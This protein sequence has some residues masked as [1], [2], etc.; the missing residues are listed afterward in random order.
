MCIDPKNDVWLIRWHIDEPQDGWVKVESCQ[1]VGKP[2]LERIKAAVISWRNA[3]IDRAI[4]SGHRWRGMPVWLSPENQ[5][6]YKATFDLAMQF[7]GDVG[8]LPVTFK[9]GTE[10]DPVYHKFTTLEELQDFYLS[11][12]QYVKHVLAEG[13]ERKDNINWT[14]YE[15]ALQAYD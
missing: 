6:N 7:A 8:A 14:F 13:W 9:F 12:V 15:Q 10:L 2:T 5:Q 4:L 11:T 1:V 3:E